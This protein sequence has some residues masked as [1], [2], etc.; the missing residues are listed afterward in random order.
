MT[1]FERTRLKRA[2]VGKIA[3][4]LLAILLGASCGAPQVD[5]GGPAQVSDDRTARPR[6]SRFSREAL[7]AM[8]FALK[9]ELETKRQN[10]VHMALQGDA[11]YAVTSDHLLYSI[12]IDK[13]VVNWIYT[14]GEPLSYSPYVY[15]YKAT[16]DSGVVRYD[17]VILLSGDRLRVVDKDT[18]ELVW[19]KD[20]PF[21]VA[22]PAA[23]TPDAIMIGSWDDRVYAISKKAPHGKT[24]MWRTSGDIR[25]AGAEYDPIYIAVSDDG[26]IYAFNQLRGEHRWTQKTKAQIT[27]RPLVHKDRLY[28]GSTDYSLYCIDLVQ[29]ALQWRFETG[30]PIHQSPVVI[31]DKVY[32]ISRDGV[33][34][35]IH[36]VQGTASGAEKEYVAGQKAWQVKLGRKNFGRSSSTRVLCRGRDDLYV[37][38]ER[39][40]VVAIN[41]ATG[42]MK[43]K[44]PFRAVDFFSVNH[45]NPSARTEQVSDRSGTIFVGFRDG[46]FYALKEKSEY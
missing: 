8:N 43:W 38:N 28:V 16:E 21:S 4:S 2:T 44:V 36:R 33:L 14:I 5:D 1:I 42:Q 25:A 9:W 3:A 6:G 31:R 13:G 46:W 35:A 40:E 37:L 15:S 19:R 29:S 18:G 26:G 27:A 11:L 34:S 7:D 22:S 12:S 17:E 45:N 30:G 32:V 23:A 24:W 20:L 41:D 39:H 10:F